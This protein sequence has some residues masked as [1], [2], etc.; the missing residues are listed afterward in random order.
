MVKNLKE[1]CEETLISATVVTE[2]N[3]FDIVRLAGKIKL[4]FKKYYNFLPPQP[5][6]LTSPIW[7]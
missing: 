2:E 5:I 6:T 7:H 4:N 3:L 1:I